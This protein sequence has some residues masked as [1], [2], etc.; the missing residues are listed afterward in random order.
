MGAILKRSKNFRPSA[1]RLRP[2]TNKTSPDFAPVRPPTSDLEPILYSLWANP[3][4]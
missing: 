4:L 2:Q 3:I 1:I